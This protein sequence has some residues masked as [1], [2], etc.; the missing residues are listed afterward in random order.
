MTRASQASWRGGELI[1]ASMIALAIAVVLFP[2]LWV[3]RL[4]VRPYSAYSSHPDGLGGG[5]TLTNFTDVWQSGAFASAFLNTAMV[6]LPGALIA[7]AVAALAGYALAKMQVPGR[8]AVLTLIVLCI[9]VPI[10]AIIIPLFSQGLSLGY[11]DSP[12][13]LGVVYGGLFASWGTY[14]LYS[15]CRTVPDALLDAARV[16]SA[17]ELQTFVRVGL[18]LL[19]PA[20]VAVLV[21]N[22]LIQWSELFL[23]LVLLPDHHTLMVT[24]ATYSGQYQTPGTLVAAATVLAVAPIAI[25][26]F[27]GQRFIRPDAFAGAMKG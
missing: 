24:V 1:R 7:T 22:L 5:L 15:F 17:T 27:V 9:A 25:V 16:E 18:P 2:L 8:R 26:Y 12:L 4:A 23:A 13:G 14:F 19:R 3:I 6:A 11:F 20:V 21:I 10:P